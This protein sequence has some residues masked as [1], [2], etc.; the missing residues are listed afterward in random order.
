MYRHKQQSHF[1][2]LHVAFPFFLALSIKEAFFPLFYVFGS[3]VELFAH[4]NMGLFLG[5]QVWEL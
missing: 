3:F 2:L 1:I 4:K 5:S